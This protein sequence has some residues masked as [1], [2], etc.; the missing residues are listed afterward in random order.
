MAI[1]WD[2]TKAK[3]KVDG[4][5]PTSWARIRGFHPT[6]VNTLMHGRYPSTGELYQRMVQQLRTDGYLVEEDEEARDMVA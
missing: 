1:N 5:T 2:M 4:R 6:I 3:I